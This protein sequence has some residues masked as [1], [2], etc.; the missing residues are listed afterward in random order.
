MYARRPLKKRKNIN[1]TN[2]IE[3][4]V[5]TVVTIENF[6]AFELPLPSSFEMRTLK[7]FRP[8]YSTGLG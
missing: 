6:A 2:A 7:I 3:K 1:S 5:I 4:D 8:K